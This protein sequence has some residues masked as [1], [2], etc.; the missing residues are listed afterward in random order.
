[1]QAGG[2]PL[3]G[4]VATPNNTVDWRQSLKLSDDDIALMNTWDVNREPRRSSH[5]PAAGGIQ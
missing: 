1:M 4:V 2:T 3:M 5:S